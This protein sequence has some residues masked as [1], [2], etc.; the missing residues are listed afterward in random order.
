[1]F[2]PQVPREIREVTQAHIEE[3]EEQ[4]R[5]MEEAVPAYSVDELM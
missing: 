5:V 1:M 3:F 2:D 4:R